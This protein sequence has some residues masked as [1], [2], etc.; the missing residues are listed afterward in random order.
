MLLQCHVKDP[1]RSAK[2]AGGRLH[3]N[4]HKHLTQRSQSG[5]TINGCPGIVWE[6]IQKQAHMQLVKGT[7]GHSH[8]SLLSLCGLILAQGVE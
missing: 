4:M 7:L 5:L 2:S 6:P 1:S 8:L 3:L